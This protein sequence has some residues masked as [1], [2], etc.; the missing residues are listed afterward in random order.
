MPVW[1]G[2]ATLIKR[3]HPSISPVY[4]QYI[5]QNPC[6]IMK[7]EPHII[8]IR[9]HRVQKIQDPDENQKIR[10]TSNKRFN[11]E[12]QHSCIV[13]SN[14]PPPPQFPKKNLFYGL[15]ICPTVRTPLTSSP[16]LLTYQQTPLKRKL[17][18]NLNRKQPNQRKLKVQVKTAINIHQ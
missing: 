18:E 1:Y 5:F 11:T 10:Q 14:L 16:H 2:V 8:E 17:S 15:F 6:R 13:P 9:I 4:L 3:R 7:N 12:Q